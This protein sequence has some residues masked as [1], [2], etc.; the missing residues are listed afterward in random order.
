MLDEF[1]ISSG[2]PDVDSKSASYPSKASLSVLLSTG[3]DT[4]TCPHEQVRYQHTNSTA[5]Y[6]K[7]CVAWS[8]TNLL[9]WTSPSVSLCKN[10]QTRYQRKRTIHTSPIRSTQ[11]AYCI[12][13]SAGE[14]LNEG[15]SVITTPHRSTVR[16]LQW[17]HTGYFLVSVDSFGGVCLWGMR[18]FNANDWD[19]LYQS[20]SKDDEEVLA[21]QWWASGLKPTVA[22]HIQPAPSNKGPNL[23]V[24][25]FSS[26]HVWSTPNGP[27]VPPG[28]LA[29]S[30]VTTSGTMRVFYR[31]TRSFA[32]SVT[33][34]RLTPTT[35]PKLTT[36][37]IGCYENGEVLIATTHTTRCQTTSR[38]RVTVH[39][40]QIGFVSSDEFPVK[41][42]VTFNSRPTYQWDIYDGLNRSLSVEKSGNGQTTTQTQTHEQTCPRRQEAWQN[43]RTS[44]PSTC[45]LAFSPTKRELYCAFTVREPMCDCSQTQTYAQSPTGTNMHAVNVDGITPTAVNTL[46]THIKSEVSGDAIGTMGMDNNSYIHGV[47]YNTKNLRTHDRTRGRI[48]ERE[49]VYLV[50][51]HLRSVTLSANPNGVFGSIPTYLQSQKQWKPASQKSWWVGLNGQDL[52]PTCLAVSTCGNYLVLGAHDGNDTLRHSHS[53]ETIASRTCTPSLDANLLTHKL[54]QATPHTSLG[55][56]N[57]TAFNVALSSNDIEMA[58]ASVDGNRLVDAGTHSMEDIKIGSDPI[59]THLDVS[60]DMGVGRDANVDVSEFVDSTLSVAVSPNGMCAASVNYKAQLVIYDL[61]SAICSATNEVWPNADSATDALQLSLLAQQTPWDILICLK[62][63]VMGSPDRS[64][65]SNIAEDITSRLTSRLQGQS[66]DVR[67]Q[68]RTQGMSL[69]NRVATLLGPVHGHLPLAL[70]AFFVLRTEQCLSIYNSVISLK[71]QPNAGAISTT[72]TMEEEAYTATEMDDMMLSRKL[73]ETGKEALLDLFAQVNLPEVEV[74]PLLPVAQYVI[75]AVVFFLKNLQHVV[76]VH[77][78]KT[79]TWSDVLRFQNRHGIPMLTILFSTRSLNAMIECLIISLA[80]RKKFASETPLDLSLLELLLNVKTLLAGDIFDQIDERNIG[81]H[82]IN[83]SKL[84]DTFAALPTALDTY[85]HPS[86]YLKELMCRLDVLPDSK[87]RCMLEQ[88]PYVILNPIPPLPDV[89]AARPMTNETYRNK[90]TFDVIR[91][92]TIPPTMRTVRECVVCG[93]SALPTLTGDSK[94]EVPLSPTRWADKWRDKCVCG[95]LWRSRVGSKDN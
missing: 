17:D 34:H 22:A 50:S 58:N 85:N 74:E 47:V 77:S 87:A 38:S 57:P 20:D 71:H 32:I 33:S 63:A 52:R 18:D 7:Q 36:V 48:R 45:S 73:G 92:A 44:L 39:G 46:S 35:F 29:F 61:R 59:P 84:K 28:K 67:N 26:S 25:P 27:Q 64:M 30:V 76:S 40:V 15:I 14:T 6:P 19:C 62:A 79:L 11:P 51:W 42:G 24:P 81:A 89:G 69:V 41:S 1:S 90:L 66:P 9:A 43:H 70:D 2:I 82:S 93:R 86:F 5:A 94:D 3:W 55:C 88:G 16:W 78:D 31:E 56:N 13:I 65:L 23:I 72:N 21:V 12:Y 10:A 75:S 83:M 54:S 95:G 91:F 53:L 37:A 4:Q 8:A 80:V 49:S 60:V 68:H